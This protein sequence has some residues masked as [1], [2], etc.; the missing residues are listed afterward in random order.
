MGM[1]NSNGAD[2]YVKQCENK[3]S[4]YEADPEFLRA[5]ALGRKWLVARC[6]Q[7]IKWRKMIDHIC[8]TFL[9]LQS[10]IA[11]SLILEVDLQLPNGI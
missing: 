9:L 2:R 5:C 8:M 4:V 11:N 1:L 10:I 6:Q 3:S 7:K